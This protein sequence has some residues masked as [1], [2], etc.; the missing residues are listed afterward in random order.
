M[1]CG[2][3][4]SVNAAGAEDFNNRKNTAGFRSIRQVRYTM[5]MISRDDIQAFVDQVAKRFRPQQVILFG[6]YAYGGTE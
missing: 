1:V 5:T 3:L 6:S 2:G 4:R